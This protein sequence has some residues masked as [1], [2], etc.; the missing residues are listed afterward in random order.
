[1]VAG[2]RPHRCVALLRFSKITLTA[3]KPNDIPKELSSLGDH[4][5]KRRLTLQQFQKG[6][7]LRLG[8]NE[9]TY[10]KWETNKNVPMIRMWPKV[11]EFLGYDPHGSPTTTAEALCSKRRRLGISRRKAA[12]MMGVDPGTLEK[13]ERGRNVPTGTHEATVRTFLKQ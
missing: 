2:A 1:M 9:W 7:S 8:I 5:K 13:W 10:H 3:L 4:L 6:V 11:I 12:A